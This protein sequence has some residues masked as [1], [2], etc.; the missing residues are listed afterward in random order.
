TAHIPPDEYAQF[1]RRFN[2]TRF[3][4]RG[5]ARLAKDAGMKYVVV[6]AK[7]HDGFAMFNSKVDAYNV[8][9]ATPFARDPVGELADACRAEGL[10]LGLYYSILDWHDPDANARGLDLYVPR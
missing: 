3:D 6:T 7:H 2:P 5:W 9:Q 1:A 4:A 8:V 10:K